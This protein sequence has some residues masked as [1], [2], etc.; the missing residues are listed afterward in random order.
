MH[1]RPRCRR[2]GWPSLTSTEGKY[3][4]YGVPVEQVVEGIKHGV[5][6]VN[7]DGLRLASTGAFADS[8][9]ESPEFDRRAA[10]ESVAMRDIC[11]A[12]PGLGCAG[13]ASRIR[14]LID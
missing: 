7:M 2:I 14:P 3:E 13:H 9:S 12:R 1:G 10:R 6:K 4:T 11:I 5:R 8:R